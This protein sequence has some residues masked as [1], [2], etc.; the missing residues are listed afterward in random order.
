VVGAKLEVKKGPL[1]TLGMGA[2]YCSRAMCGGGRR[3]RRG[4]LLQVE[5]WRRSGERVEENVYISNN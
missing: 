1:L 5:G 2:F 3:R 4:N